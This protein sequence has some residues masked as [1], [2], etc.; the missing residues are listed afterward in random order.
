LLDI[1]HIPAL[2]HCKMRIHVPTDHYSTGADALA[3]GEGLEFS[4]ARLQ[5]LLARMQAKNHDAGMQPLIDEGIALCA[6][7]RAQASDA[8]LGP[9]QPREEDSVDPQVFERLMALAG[10][11][12]AVELLD[13]LQ[14]DLRSALAAVQAAA[15][16][17]DLPGLRIQCHI[18]VAVAGSVGAYEVQRTAEHLQL[19]VYQ[20]DTGAINGLLVGLDHR[21]QTLIRFVEIQRKRRSVL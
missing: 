1:G 20:A 5:D 13:Q 17:P 6:H 10:P 19:A 21:L 11:A 8:S 7:L 2:E 9:V 3:G 14:V 4:L 15:L 16:G 18:L 12:M